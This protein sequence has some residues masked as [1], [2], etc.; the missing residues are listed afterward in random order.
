MNEIGKIRLITL[1]LFYFLTG[2]SFGALASLNVLSGNNSVEGL[3][4]VIQA[5]LYAFA[6]LLLAGVVQPLR[7]L[8]L[9][10]FSLTWKSIW[11]MAFVIPV[12]VDG[13]LDGHTKTILM[14]V[15]GGLIVTSAVIPWG[16]TMR[17]YCKFKTDV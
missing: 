15:L 17:R 11:I 9:L 3:T 14:A 7:M 12:Y 6:L 16:Y 13:G 10:F 8:P 2:V 4:D 1:R 5:V